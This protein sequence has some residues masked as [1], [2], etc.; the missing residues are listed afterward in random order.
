MTTPD[1]DRSLEQW[2]RHT[3]ASGAGPDECL[4]PE[5]LAAWA[6]GLI[7]GPA[8]ATVESHAA[9]CARCQAMLAVMAR[10]APAPSRALGW[11]SPKRVMMLGPAVAAMAAVV[12]WVAVD[13]ATRPGA[14]EPATAM[15]ASVPPRAESAADA[16]ASGV[17][18]VPPDQRTME[19]ALEA[20]TA[21]K[22]APEPA[23]KESK[24]TTS[25]FAQ[26]GRER[27]SR[28]NEQGRGAPPPAS[29]KPAPPA[30]S[31]PL[32]AANQ[33]GAMPAPPTGPAPQQFGQIASNQ[34]PLGQAQGNQAQADRGQAKQS[35]SQ[36]QAAQAAERQVRSE[37]ST[38][39]LKKAESQPVIVTAEKDRALAA[40]PAPAAAPTPAP[41]PAPATAPP[42]KPPGDRDRAALTE[43]RRADALLAD[44]AKHSAD[45]VAPD[46]S[47]RWRVDD[48]RVVLRSDDNGA[49]WTISYTA[50]ADVELTAGAS[51]S[52]TVC[53]F[54]GRAGAVILTTDGRQWRTVK[55]PERTDLVSVTASG[56]RSA[57]VTTADGRVFATADG[58]ATWTR[59]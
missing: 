19:S 7:T 47:V 21:S 49:T 34:S 27:A 24:E 42:Q 36:T 56:P 3:P 51:A 14:V 15:S 32:S 18:A 5:M 28:E 52:P 44:R 2:L 40:T 12:L 29:A 43:F 39:P 33:T 31:V 45:V 22:R 17:P 1:R 4:E 23:D 11:F 37:P 10:T 16:V 54:V 13:R 59:R 46:N 30:E 58:G 38:E 48:S 6:E 53:W 41:A 55:F 25:R 20:V 57:S 35:V 50:G 8:R 9:R 26:A